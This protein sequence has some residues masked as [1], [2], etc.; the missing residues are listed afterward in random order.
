M[1]LSKRSV[2][3]IGLLLVCF[4]FSVELA[5]PQSRQEQKGSKYQRRL[6]SDRELVKA[7]RQRGLRSKAPIKK[8]EGEDDQGRFVSI[9]EVREALQESHQASQQLAQ[10]A[11]RLA[12]LCE[13]LSSR[14][15]EL[16]LFR[17]QARD[18]LSYLS[19][20]S[21]AI[22][23]DQVLDLLASGFEVEVDKPQPNLT[24]KKFQGYS[25]Q[26]QWM[27]DRLGERI[28]FFYQDRDFSQVRLDEIQL[29]SAQSLSEGIQS[30]S[31]SLLLAAKKSKLLTA[32]TG[33]SSSQ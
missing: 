15:I 2:T 12:E 28:D 22:Q 23:K 18:E 25:E 29:P 4:S 21:K 31:G 7:L 17:K 30:L 33:Q 14:S 27:A 26:I 11:R 3:R 13:R 6:E 32:E 9:E 1:I 8:G 24:L 10:S 20:L 19:K 16:P 5:L